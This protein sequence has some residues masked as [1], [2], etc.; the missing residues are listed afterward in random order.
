[1][2]EPTVD[3][4]STLV[5]P[6]R[7]W[8]TIILA[9]VFVLSIILGAGPGVLLVNRP[10]TIVGVPLVYAWGILWYIVQ[11]IV[12]LIAYFTTWKQAAEDMECDRWGAPQT[13]YGDG[14]PA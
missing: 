13:I 5:R 1:M 6:A 4:T 9:V 10:E 12:V 7:K 11:V 14:E 3:A 2:S 8:L